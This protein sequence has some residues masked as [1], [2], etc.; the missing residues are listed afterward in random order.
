LA[1]IGGRAHLNGITFV[2]DTHIVR[3]KIS[4]GSVSING[5]RL[6]IECDG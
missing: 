2:T 5:C 1:V 4:H 3:G 6:A